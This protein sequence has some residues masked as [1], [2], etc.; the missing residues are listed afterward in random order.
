M[1]ENPAILASAETCEFWKI[2]DDVYRSPV[3]SIKDVWNCPAS[4]RWECSYSHWLKYREVYSW[5]T[6]VSS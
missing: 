1:T 4:I 2:G 6:D 3:N 5:A